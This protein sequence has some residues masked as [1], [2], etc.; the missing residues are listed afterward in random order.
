MKPSPSSSSSNRKLKGD[1]ETISSSSVATIARTL[2][3]Q[4]DVSASPT[5][6]SNLRVTASEESPSND[7][8]PHQIVP[9]LMPT[10]PLNTTDTHLIQPPI[11]PWCGVQEDDYEHECTRLTFLDLES[12]NKHSV[13]WYYDKSSLMKVR[14]KNINVIGEQ[15]YFGYIINGLEW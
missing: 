3:N 7:V 12:N 6:V 15:G 14:N 8:G 2:P 10:Q 1:I 5:R 13:R 11:I 4:N 9:S